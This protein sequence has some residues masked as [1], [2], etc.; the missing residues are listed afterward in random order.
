MKVIKYI[1]LGVFVG[2]GLMTACHRSSKDLSL[3]EPEQKAASENF[4]I[5][6]PL[7]ANTF[8]GV[9]PIPE[10]TISFAYDFLYT[11][12]PTTGLRD[13]LLNVPRNTYF[14]ATFN[15]SITWTLDIVG[16]ASHAT[17]RISAKSSVIDSSNSWWNGGADGAHLFLQGEKA[18]VT[19]TILGS[20]ISQTKEFYIHKARTYDSSQ[21]VL[22]TDFEGVLGTIYYYGDKN[23]PHYYPA[24]SRT[25]TLNAPQGAFSVL[26]QGTDN[27]GDYFVGGLNTEVFLWTKKV[28]TNMPISDI[29]INMYVYGFDPSYGLTPKATTVEISV[30]EDDNGKNKFEPEKEDTWGQQVAVDWVGWK[31][32]SVR[33]SNLVRSVS[34]QNGGSGN[35]IK[36]PGK[37]YTINCNLL[38][39]PNGSK[40]GAAVDYIIVTFGKPYQQ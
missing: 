24:P 29:Y 19:L 21:A 22:V 36:E 8:N 4:A 16:S 10:D 33:Y 6:S 9:K 15:E 38:S 27:N 11:T 20:T 37:A 3:L 40:V 17:K 26:M 18:Q 35:N 30:S 31:L 5:T 12:N 2:L 1:L 7:K 14:S 23:D 25:T 13:T 39:Q 32:V 34:K 28:L